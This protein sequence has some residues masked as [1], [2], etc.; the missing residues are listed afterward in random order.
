LPPET[1]LEP[2]KPAAKSY[3]VSGSKLLAA[4]ALG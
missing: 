4:T 2:S 1:L 3:A